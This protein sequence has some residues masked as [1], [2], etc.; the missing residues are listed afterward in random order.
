MCTAVDEGLIWKRTDFLNNCVVH[1]LR[2]ARVEVAAASHKQGVPS[3]LETETDQASVSVSAVCML[4]AWALTH[5]LGK[6]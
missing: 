6:P 2:R 4:E 1:L 3:E 5:T